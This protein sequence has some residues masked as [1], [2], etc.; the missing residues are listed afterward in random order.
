LHDDRKHD[1]LRMGNELQVK[2]EE[3]IQHVA[4]YRNKYAFKNLIEND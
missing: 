4:L 2:V 1:Y 3:I